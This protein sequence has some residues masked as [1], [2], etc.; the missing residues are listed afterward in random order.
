MD[1]SLT[2]EQEM[3]RETAA[4]L[5]ERIGP[6]TPH[7]LDP[8][9]PASDGSPAKHWSLLADAGLLGLA[10][11]TASGG[12][13][14]SAV[15]T[16]IVAEALAR[17]VCPVPYLGVTLALDLLAAADA[18]RDL[19]ESLVAGD[20][21]L[22]VALDGV[23]GGL[24]TLGSSEALVAWDAAGADAALALDRDGRL[25][26]VPV[27]ADAGRGSDLTRATVRLDPGAAQPARDDLGLGTLGHPID[28]AGLTRWR[29]LAL[30]LLAADIV[31]AMDGTLTAAVEYSKERVQ[32]DTRI[33]A[34]Q[35]IQH[36]CADAYI[37]LEGARSATWYA[38]WA[39][40]AETPDRALQVARTAKA[41]ASQSG[42]TVAETS[43]QVHGGVA[44]TWEYMPHVFLRRILLDRATLGA[45]DRQ[46]QDIAAERR[47]QA[48]RSGRTSGQ[49]E[50]A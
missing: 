41:F 32:F 46:L 50:A 48:A 44:I 6:V 30:G 37:L 17:R 40:G 20:R 45:E 15:E 11:P 18:D 22:T 7:D 34:F 13:G 47:D 38:S 10:V 42:V 27:D 31:G 26:A 39:V 33:G 2:Q 14:A 36:L 29:A 43:V 16:M 12:G 9:A 8:P 5:A 21:R 35:A 4:S 23:L 24:A 25:V 3:L 28:A 19:V 1:V 49:P